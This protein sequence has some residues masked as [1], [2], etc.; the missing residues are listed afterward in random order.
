MTRP[1]I[2]TRP[3]FHGLFNQ[4]KQ[5]YCSARFLLFEGIYNK[6]IH[7][8]DT[9]VYLVDTFDFPVYNLNIEKIKSSY[10]SIYSIFDRI[11]YF[12][13]KYFDLGIMDN[14]IS[15]NRIWSRD[16]RILKKTYEPGK[17]FKIKDDNYLLRGLYWIKKDL[18]DKTDSGYKG[19]INPSLNR[20]YKIRNTMEHKYLKII[21]EKFTNIN[22]ADDSLVSMVITLQE[23]EELSIDLL[24]I[25]HEAII[26]L[27]QVVYVEEMKNSNEPSFEVT[28]PEFRDEWKF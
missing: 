23:F 21:D 19:V 7:Y 26:L 4:I 5:E 8:S 18:Y 9:N 3:L 24:K 22:E 27:T 6:S 1:T 13:N 20:T 12:L 15:F 25:V 11:A 16:T 2:E 10:R 28:L 14:K 17:I